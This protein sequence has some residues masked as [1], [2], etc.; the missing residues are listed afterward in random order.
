MPRFLDMVICD[1]C[2]RDA[3]KLDHDCDDV[4]TEIRKKEAPVLR[5][6]PKPRTDKYAPGKTIPLFE[7]EDVET[8]HGT[9]SDIVPY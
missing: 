4:W 3:R 8:D 9:D 1:F 5:K 2:T 6:L 7:T